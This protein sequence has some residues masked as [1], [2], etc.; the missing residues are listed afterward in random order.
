VDAT[1]GSRTIITAMKKVA[2]VVAVLVGGSIPYVAQQPIAIPSLIP[3]AP[4]ALSPTDHPALPKDVS[5]Y[6]FVPGTDATGNAS[7]DAYA[8]LARGARAIGNGC[9]V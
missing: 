2:V 9:G 6:W 8:S 1:Q 7:R 4:V 5:Q 3:P